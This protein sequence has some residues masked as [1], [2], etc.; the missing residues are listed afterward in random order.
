[1][2]HRQA[3]GV[4]ITH[5]EHRDHVLLVHCAGK[6]HYDL[7]GGIVEPGELP[8]EAAE[9]ELKEELGLN[10]PHLPTV[11]TPPRLLAAHTI[12]SAGRSSMFTAYVFD[13]GQLTN[14]VNLIRV[15]GVE[16]TGWSWCDA[17]MRKDVLATAPLLHAR[18]AVALAN[19]RT[20]KT[21]YFETHS[22][23]EPS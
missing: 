21:T 20:R 17:T 8:S 15:D 16:V 6:D 22:T 1:M 19:Q 2:N 12:L 14:S 9:R 10:L 18:I 11:T 4:L 3:A 5:R 7:P 23:K 13:G